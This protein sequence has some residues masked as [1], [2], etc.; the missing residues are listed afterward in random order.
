LKRKKKT[1]AKTEKDPH[2][3]LIWS[4]T[5]F[6]THLLLMEGKN[7]ETDYKH[8]CSCILILIFSWSGCPSMLVIGNA[9]I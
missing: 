4:A 3:S 9:A 1:T 8:S 5:A 6:R 7:Q 2:S